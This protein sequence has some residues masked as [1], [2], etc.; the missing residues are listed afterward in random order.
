M[1]STPPLT[2]Q[3]C[4]HGSLNCNISGAFLGS[5]KS[6]FSPLSLLINATKK[7]KNNNWRHSRATC[8]CCCCCCCCPVGSSLT[9]KTTQPHLLS[10]TTCCIDSPDT[11]KQF[12]YSV[13]FIKRPA[14]LILSSLSSLS[15]GGHRR[16]Q[17][18]SGELLLDCS[19]SKWSTFLPR[20]V[21]FGSKL[22]WCGQSNSRA[23]QLLSSLS[24]L[25][26]RVHK[27][28]DDDDN[29]SVWPLTGLCTKLMF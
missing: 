9:S 1:N 24:S 20:L 19:T 25:T 21:L 23:G 6:A 4:K 16:T 5:A 14:C 22:L 13:S 3:D 29:L 11:R 18:S 7:R 17:R 27:N 10:S 12:E 26:W 15:S 8:C 28:D 2:P